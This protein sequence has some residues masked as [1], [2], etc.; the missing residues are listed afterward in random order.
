MENHTYK[1][2]LKWENNRKGIMSSPELPT[3]IEVATPPEFEKGM[4][5]I[6]S[7]EHL[8]TASVI[9][10]FMTTF[11]AISEH[12]KL[13]FIS[14]EC[15]AEGILEK[16]DGKYLMTKIILKPTLTI[17]DLNKIEKAQRVLELSEKACLISNSI[18]SEVELKPII[19]IE[20]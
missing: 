1:V 17:A 7:P 10:C 9:S 11:L 15:N 2:N 3:T 16:I 4:P 20:N 14:F 12:S 13:D 8:F 6:W 19:N 18:K 5:N